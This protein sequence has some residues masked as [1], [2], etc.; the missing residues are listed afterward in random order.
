MSCGSKTSCVA[1]QG[2]GELYEALLPGIVDWTGWGGAWTGLGLDR[3]SARKGPPCEFQAGS[4]SDRWKLV[5]G[6]RD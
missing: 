3:R 4:V 6:A 1:M 5:C 2:C